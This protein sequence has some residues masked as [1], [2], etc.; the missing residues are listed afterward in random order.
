MEYT[1]QNDAHMY[2]QYQQYESEVK[3]EVIDPQY[4]TH[5]QQPMQ[6]RVVDYQHYQQQQRV[7]SH[8]HQRKQ[9]NP[10]QRERLA[11][12]KVGHVVIFYLKLEFCMIKFELLGIKF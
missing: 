1:M 3:E 9:S 2:Q 8:Q 6:H 11:A 5:Q 12:K 10:Q 4:F 7:V